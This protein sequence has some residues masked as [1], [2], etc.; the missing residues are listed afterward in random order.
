MTWKWEQFQLTADFMRFAQD[1]I[2]CLKMISL[3]AMF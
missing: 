1:D 3:E 2:K